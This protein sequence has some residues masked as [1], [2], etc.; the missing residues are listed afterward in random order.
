MVEVQG[1]TDFVS[2]TYTDKSIVCS[3]M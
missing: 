1:M 3:G 2:L